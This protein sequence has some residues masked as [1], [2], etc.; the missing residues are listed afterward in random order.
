MDEDA[1]PE[2]R[3]AEVPADGAPVPPPEQVRAGSGRRQRSSFVEAL[4]LVFVALL[5]ALT[6]KT[7]VAE[8]YEIKGRS[9]EPT[10]NDGERVVVLKARALYDIERGDIIVFSSR[11]DPSKDLIKR[12]IGLPGDTVRIERGRVYVNGSREPLTEEYVK[13]DGGYGYGGNRI[14]KK[15]GPDEYYVLGDNRRDSCDSRRFS[16]V[17]AK[18]IKGKV[19]VRWWPLEEF[20]SF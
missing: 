11:D 5:L 2:S 14:E 15:I 9:M 16:G 10:F 18:N 7:Y 1:E 6:L 17:P 20:A 12:V 8:A 3:P 4:A 19:I 13:D